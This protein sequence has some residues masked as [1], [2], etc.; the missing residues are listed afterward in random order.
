MNKLNDL[1]IRLISSSQWIM[2][3]NLGL[4]GMIGYSMVELLLTS[5]TM[6]WVQRIPH[7]QLL[8]QLK[9][10]QSV[11]KV[12]LDI[13]VL[14]QAYL[15]GNPPE[16]ST[17]RAADIQLLPQTHLDLKLHGIYY[18][19]N[20]HTSFAM[21][22]DSLGKTNLYHA[23]ESL[24]GGIILHEIHKKHVTLLRNGQ[25][26][27]LN[28]L[29]SKNPTLIT[30]TTN[31]AK[32]AQNVSNTDELSPEQLLGHYQ[33]QLQTDPNSLMK[34]IRILPINQG[35]RLVGYQVNPGEDSHLLNRFNLQP[36]DILTTINGIKLDNPINGLSAIQQLANAE[37]I[38]L[39]VLRN[40]Q[41]LSFAFNVE[42]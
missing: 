36:G 37:Q 24:P 11:T 28:L 25:S 30:T 19:S 38:N 20:R 34:L 39:E 12:N 16:I 3:I 32:N 4:C 18:S 15:F 13:S 27:I 29:D 41:P 14:K 26:E 8:P 33:N 6:S 7:N 5:P 23:N 17:Q 42:K 1:L 22:A 2:V 10:A 21:I 9:P 40:Q 31:Y 35:G